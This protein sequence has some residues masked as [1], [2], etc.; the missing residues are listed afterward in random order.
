MK[1]AGHVGKKCGTSRINWTTCFP[2]GRT[3][4]LPGGRVPLRSMNCRASTATTSRAFLAAA[5]WG[6]SF[7]PGICVWAVPWRSRCCSPAHTRDR[8]NW[9]GSS[10]KRKPSPDCAIPNVVQIYEVGDHE[11]RPY[12][13][14][15]F[16][17][18][19]S[20]AQKLAETSPTKGIRTNRSW[21]AELVATLAEAV[22][23][24]PPRRHHSS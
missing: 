21:A 6:S 14:M 16:V 20:L 9:R 1:C 24:R 10:L 7:V 3:G 5:E 23:R 17:D 11:G 13:T 4:L 8:R 18:G 19:G 15:E 12:F 2:S 22:S